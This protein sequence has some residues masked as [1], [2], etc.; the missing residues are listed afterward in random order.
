VG[1]GQHLAW[2]EAP[3]SAVSASSTNSFSAT[4]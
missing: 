4:P 3:P 2:R 1:V